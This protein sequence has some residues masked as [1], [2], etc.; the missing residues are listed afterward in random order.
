M[1]SLRKTLLAVTAVCLALGLAAAATACSDKRP[2]STHPVTQPKDYVI[3][4]E[5]DDEEVLA[6]VLPDAVCGAQPALVH[7]KIVAEGIFREL[8]FVRFDYI[9]R[10]LECLLV[11]YDFHMVE[12][13]IH[14]YS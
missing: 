11:C 10:E 6:G 7:E 13:R 8:P 1:R 2:A 14:C 4:V 3:T 12:A 9:E 5:C